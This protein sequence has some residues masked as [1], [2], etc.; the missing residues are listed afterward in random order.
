MAPH[1]ICDSI[2]QVGEEQTGFTIMIISFILPKA[3]K[4]FIA[5]LSVARENS[6]I[7][8][9]EPGGLPSRAQAAGR[10]ELT[11]AEAMQLYMEWRKEMRRAQTLHS[12]HTPTPL[13]HLCAPK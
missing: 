5:T 4:S 2:K 8:L 13:L 1:K 7:C 3:V 6:S 10:R 9:Q 12:H 11:T